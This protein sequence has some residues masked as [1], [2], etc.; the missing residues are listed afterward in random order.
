MVK[1]DL[2]IGFYVELGLR[3]GHPNHHSH[4]KVFDPTSIPFPTR[5]LT[6]QEREETMHVVNATC[7]NASGRNFTK[8]K[9]GKFINTIKIIYLS[10]KTSEKYDSAKDDIELMIDDFE[11]SDGISFVALSNVPMKEFFPDL[12]E[13]TKDDTV[14]ISSHT[15]SPGCVISQKIKD[16]ADMSDLADMVAQERVEHNQIST[17]NLFITVAWIVKPAFRL[18]MLCPEAIWIDVTSHSNNKGSDLLTLSS[19]TSIGKQ[20]VFMRIFIPN[21][22]R[23]SFQ[24]VLQEAIP[25]LVPKWLCDC[26]LFF[27]KDADPQQRNELLGAMVNVFVNAHEGTCGFHVVNMGWKKHVPNANVITTRNRRKWVSVVQKVHNLIYS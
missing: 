26:V 1:W 6:S 20:V 23:F 9:M 14:T 25:T 19:K 5:L 22:Q 16:H 21:K 13:D 12:A 17:E 11:S 4:P 7:S 10:N 24:W 8:V 15:S 18:F 2:L 3:S 27:M